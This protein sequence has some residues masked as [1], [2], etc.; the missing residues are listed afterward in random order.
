MTCG[1]WSQAGFEPWSL[2]YMAALTFLGFKQHGKKKLSSEYA[3]VMCPVDV[4][5]VQC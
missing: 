2:V 5:L 1:K 3:Y 4:T